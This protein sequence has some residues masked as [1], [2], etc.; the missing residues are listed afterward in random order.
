MMC[1]RDAV[2]GGRW[3]VRLR[4]GGGRRRVLLLLRGGAAVMGEGM[5]VRVGEWGKMDGAA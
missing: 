3:G 4:L 5:G 2:G 1:G